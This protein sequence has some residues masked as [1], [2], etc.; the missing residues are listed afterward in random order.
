MRFYERYVV[1]RGS[2][3]TTQP[4]WVCRCGDERYVREE[5]ATDVDEQ[6]GTRLKST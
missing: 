3:S 4:A 2:V 5:S 6:H 1:R